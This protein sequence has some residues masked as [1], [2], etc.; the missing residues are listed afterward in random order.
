MDSNDHPFNTI[1]P[2]KNRVTEF[3]NRRDINKVIKETKYLIRV[4]NTTIIM[5]N[6]MTFFLY[7]IYAI[8]N[9]KSNLDFLQRVIYSSLWK[10]Y[11]VQSS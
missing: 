4:T 7:I 1:Q 5:F 9:Y 11:I 10:T 2:Y 3:W 6:N 8:G